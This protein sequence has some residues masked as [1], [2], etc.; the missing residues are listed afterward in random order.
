MILADNFDVKWTKYL[1]V[2]VAKNFNV[3]TNQAEIGFISLYWLSENGKKLEFIHK[4]P[5]E[6]LP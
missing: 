6:T 2:G 5:T 4:T 3:S 1:I